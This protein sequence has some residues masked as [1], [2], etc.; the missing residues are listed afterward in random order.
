M[1]EGLISLFLTA[2]LAVG[3]LQLHLQLLRQTQE[4][5][6]KTVFMREIQEEVKSRL[7]GAPLSSQFEL[8]IYR[9]A[10]GQII[11]IRAE[12]GSEVFDWQK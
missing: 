9:D 8:Q 1:L 10:S 12:K 6:D 3:C 5:M 11:R 2:G 7:N 4:R